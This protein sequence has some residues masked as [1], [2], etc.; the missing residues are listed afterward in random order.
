MNVLHNAPKLIYRDLKSQYFSG[1]ACTLDPPSPP[2]KGGL[3]QP[4]Y[5]P[6]CYKLS[7]YATVVV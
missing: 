2:Y 5:Q 6:P 7:S 3:G 1:E 4:H